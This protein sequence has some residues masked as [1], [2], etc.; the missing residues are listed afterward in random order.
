MEKVYCIHRKEDVQR[1]QNIRGQLTKV[2]FDVE[3]VEPEAVDEEFEEVH[4]LNKAMDSLKRTTIKIIE[5]AKADDLDY[6]MI[7]EDDCVFDKHGMKTFLDSSKPE[8]FWFIHLNVVGNSAR[9]GFD[10]EGIYTKLIKGECCQFYIV[11]KDAYDDYLR[12]L[13]ANK[14]PIDYITSYMH[15]KYKK[16]WCV[17]PFPVKHITGKY[18]TLKDS[19]VNY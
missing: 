1:A 5:Q 3:F 10:K 9:F 11:S 15:Q 8:G 16:S 6:V 4:F 17:D 7:M 2:R 13:K 14:M 19:V 18:S 12:L